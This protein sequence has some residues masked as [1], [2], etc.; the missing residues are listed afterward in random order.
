[1][2]RN[3]LKSIY[4]QFA[5]A[6]NRRDLDALDQ[7]FDPELINHGAD[8]D[9][10]RGAYHFKQV[11]RNFIAACPDLQVTIEDSITK[12]DKLVVRWTD[13]GT[14]TGAPLLGVPAT[15]KQIILTGIDILRI[16][17]GKIVERWAENDMRYLMETLGLI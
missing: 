9:E 6:V 3:D 2:A 11:F 17:D 5:D 8:P 1:M 10:P 4:Q 16:R 15:G 14:H 13:T 12:D 7:I